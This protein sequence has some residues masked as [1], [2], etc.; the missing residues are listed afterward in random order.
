[1][2]VNKDDCT[3]CMLRCRKCACNISE[4]SLVSEAGKSGVNA[5]V[6]VRII[7]G[8]IEILSEFSKSQ[9]AYYTWGRIIH[10]NLW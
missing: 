9:G 2:N 8:N 10:G 3:G 1:M 5:K 6:G 7:H 4:L